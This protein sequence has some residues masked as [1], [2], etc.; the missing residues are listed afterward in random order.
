MK[1]R[2]SLRGCVDGYF[3]EWHWTQQARNRE[4][5]KVKSLFGSRGH[6]LIKRKEA[7]APSP[8]EPMGWTNAKDQRPL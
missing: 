7:S 5:E 6:P 8:F 1:I 4:R 3:W 2:K